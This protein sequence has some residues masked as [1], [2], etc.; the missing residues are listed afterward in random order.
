VIV[1]G[2]GQSV[3]VIIRVHRC[4]GDCGRGDRGW[5]RRYRGVIVVGPGKQVCA[6]RVSDVAIL[7]YRRD[8]SWLRTVVAV[9]CAGGWVV[10]GLLA[11]LDRR[12]VKVFGK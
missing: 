5:A 3:G 7:V 12:A 8:S 4:V 10:R 1:V 2:C 11:E 6:F 9:G